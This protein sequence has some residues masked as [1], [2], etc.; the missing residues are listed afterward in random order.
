LGG[1]S[2]SQTAVSAALAVDHHPRSVPVDALVKR[3]QGRER[4][5]AGVLVGDLLESGRP[6][7]F[8]MVDRSIYISSL[9]VVEGVDDRGPIIGRCRLLKGPGQPSAFWPGMASRRAPTPER[10]VDRFDGTCS[11]WRGVG[12]VWHVEGAPVSGGPG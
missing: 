9:S 4:V 1:R 2:S 7:G 6:I 3:A 12:V 5:G 10:A 11:L 8:P